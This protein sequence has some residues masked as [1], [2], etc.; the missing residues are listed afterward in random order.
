MRFSTANFRIRIHEKTV[1]GLA[2][3][4]QETS[5]IP[6]KMCTNIIYSRGLQLAYIYIYMNMFTNAPISESDTVLSKRNASSDRT[7]PNSSDPILDNPTFLNENYCRTVRSVGLHVVVELGLNLK[8]VSAGVY[9]C[10]SWCRQIRPPE[11]FSCSSTVD[12]RGNY[13]IKRENCWA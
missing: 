7:S 1:L 6:I 5:V 4:R 11:A 8:P 12:N 2:E 3:P 10:R 13:E 9:V